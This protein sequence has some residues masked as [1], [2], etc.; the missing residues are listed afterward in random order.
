MQVSDEIKHRRRE[1]PKVAV[2]K[3]RTVSKVMQTLTKVVFRE[4]EFLEGL[5]LGRVL[6]IFWSM[7]ESN[8]S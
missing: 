7:C 4:S 2:Y 6:H 8:Q 3:Y 1:D 5:V